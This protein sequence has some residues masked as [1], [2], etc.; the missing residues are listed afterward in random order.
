MEMVETKPVTKYSERNI[1]IQYIDILEVDAKP[2]YGTINV[3]NKRG[4]MW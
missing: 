2:L 1:Q 4:V 3:G